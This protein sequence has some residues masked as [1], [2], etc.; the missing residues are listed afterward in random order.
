MKNQY[1]IA[2]MA[3]EVS[4]MSRRCNHNQSPLIKI[5]YSQVR[6]NGR[7]E[8]IPMELYADGSLKRSE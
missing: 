1:A 8:L 6:I 7:V 4:Y 3:F 5:V 2:L